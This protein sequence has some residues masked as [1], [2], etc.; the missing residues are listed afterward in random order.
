MRNLS[1]ST[2]LSSRSNG[3]PS[4]RGNSTQ[5]DIGETRAEFIAIREDHA[6]FVQAVYKRFDITK[7]RLNAR[8]DAVDIR[9]DTFTTTFDERLESLTNLFTQL[10]MKVSTA[11]TSYADALKTGLTTSAAATINA[12]TSQGTPI[13]QIFSINP[14][15]S[16]SQQGTASSPHVVIDFSTAER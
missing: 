15:S 12:T 1:N 16:A 11:T 13:M 3:W 14:S 7:G 2:A 4:R 10:R 6:A 9:I 5:E 8:L